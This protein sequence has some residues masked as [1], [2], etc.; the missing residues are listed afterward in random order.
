MAIAAKGDEVGNVV[1]SPVGEALLVV[2]LEPGVQLLLA[3]SAGPALGRCHV[4]SL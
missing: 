1:A 3:T 4:L 2:D